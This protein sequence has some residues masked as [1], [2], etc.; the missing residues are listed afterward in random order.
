[1][2]G[3]PY[4]RGTARYPWKVDT[5]IIPK[6]ADE[7]YQTCSFKVEVLHAHI[8]RVSIYCIQNP[9]SKDIGTPFKL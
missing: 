4:L 1:M 7:D 8:L 2:G 3:Y 9:A 6:Q 5:P